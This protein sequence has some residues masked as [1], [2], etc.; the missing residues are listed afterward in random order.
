MALF[1]NEVRREFI[2]GLA[3]SALARPASTRVSFPRLPDIEEPDAR[4]AAPQR[5]PS[6]P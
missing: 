5:S 2:A 3:A 4:I 6:A 1:D